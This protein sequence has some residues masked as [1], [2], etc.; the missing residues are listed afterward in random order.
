MNE[1]A[2]KYR[3]LEIAKESN[4]DF[5]TI[6]T[7]LAEERFLARLSHHKI[8][9]HFILKGGNLIANLLPTRRRTMDIDFAIKNLKSTP[10]GLTDFVLQIMTIN[11]DDGFSFTDLESEPLTHHQMEEPG[12]R[13][14][15]T[16]QIGKMKN[17]IQIDLAIGDVAEPI[18]IPYNHIKYHN[19][20]L[21]PGEISLLAYSLE[22]QCAEKIQ[23]I[24][25]LGEATSRLRDFYD[26]FLMI[27]SNKLDQKKLK[28]ILK[29]SLRSSIII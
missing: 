26:V 20:P 18:L 1:Q 14:K 24:M 12:I 4:V 9:E 11:L 23:I 16:Y 21:Y 5:Q 17:K 28:Q 29:V 22:Y 25:S 10:K 15:I 7:K 2:L 8:K 27:N 19:K 3:L 13:F 6:L